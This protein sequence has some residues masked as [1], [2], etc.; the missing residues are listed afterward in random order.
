MNYRS[1]RF[2][3]LALGMTQRDIAEQAGV[4][5]TTVHHFEVNS[6]NIRPN[7]EARI[8]EVYTEL[9][10]NMRYSELILAL[11]MELKNTKSRKVKKSIKEDIIRYLDKV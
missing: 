5:I 7:T 9:F 10:N 3:R 1:E 8:K 2:I 4:S 6:N 11:A